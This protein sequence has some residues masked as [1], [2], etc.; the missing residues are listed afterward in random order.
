M[1]SSHYCKASRRILLLCWDFEAV[2]SGRQDCMH[3]YV[4]STSPSSTSHG[5]KHED[6]N[7]QI[8]SSLRGANSPNLGLP[9]TVELECYKLPSQGAQNIS[10]ADLC[11]LRNLISTHTGSQQMDQYLM[12][13]TWRD[14]STLMRCSRVAVNGV[15]TVTSPECTAAQGSSR[16]VVVPAATT[17]MF[18][19]CTPSPDFH[20]MSLCRLWYSVLLCIADFLSRMHTS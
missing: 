11:S 14:W 7:I 3:S 15:V 13:P 5:N 10:S 6:Y 17:T 9:H 2:F 4:A 12:R 16:D 19:I 18:F 1:D 8:K 20:Y